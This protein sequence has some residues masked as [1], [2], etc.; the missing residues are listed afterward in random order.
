MNAQ[1]ESFIYLF[2][3]KSGQESYHCLMK[4]QT[5][6]TEFLKLFYGKSSVTD[7]VRQIREKITIN[8]EKE[9]SSKIV[10]F[11]QYD[12]KTMME[13]RIHLVPRRF[14]GIGQVN[15]CHQN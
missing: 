15:E 6:A 2:F 8:N 3:L 4:R 11:Q 12:G 7:S 10:H 13:E 5:S 9:R 14:K 1:S